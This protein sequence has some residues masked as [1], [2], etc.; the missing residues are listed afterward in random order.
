MKPPNG[1]TRKACGSPLCLLSIFFREPKTVQHL[2]IEWSE[3]SAKLIEQAPAIHQSLVEGRFMPDYEAWQAG[4]IGW[5]LELA[6][7]RMI[8]GADLPEGW[9]SQLIREW[10]EENPEVRANL[11]QLEQSYPLL[12]RAGRAANVWLDEED[13]LVSIGWQQD[14]SAFR[15]CLRLSEPE[16]GESAGSCIFC[17]RTGRTRM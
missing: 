6:G 12:R 7:N 10:A 13:W 2:P 1:T 11:R 16:E 17:C 3:D 9:I 5:K 8:S 15:T 4:E 14:R